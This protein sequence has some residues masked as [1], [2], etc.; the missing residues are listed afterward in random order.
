MAPTPTELPPTELPEP[1]AAL[2]NLVEQRDGVRRARFLT[3]AL[4]AVPQLQQWLREQRQQTVRELKQ[5]RDMSN[6]QIAPYLDCTPQRVA[7]IASGHGRSRAP[8][9]PRPA[10]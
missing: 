8:R 5:Q 6:E 9:P 1:F 2:L 7:D 3:D 4:K 10:R